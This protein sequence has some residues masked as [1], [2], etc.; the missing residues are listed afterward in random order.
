MSGTFG[1]EAAQAQL[2]AIAKRARRPLD[3][4]RTALLRGIC[5]AY[6]AERA[7]I[8][9][10]TGALRTSLTEPGSPLQRLTV[11]GD[12]LTF[13]SLVPYAPYQTRNLPKIKTSHL[14]KIIERY[15]VEGRTR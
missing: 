9:Q 12:R 8:P 14:G 15:V 4:P 5:A 6:D 3:E 10:R 1:F 11:Q 7:R 2:A 13:E